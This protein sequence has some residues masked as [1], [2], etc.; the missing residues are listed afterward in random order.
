[1]VWSN[2]RSECE[3]FA[4]AFVYINTYNPFAFNSQIAYL[5]FIVIFKGENDEFYKDLL[6][7]AEYKA[8]SVKK[9]KKLNTLFASH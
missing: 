7:T 3:Q 8:S 6:Y 5:R 2:L 9:Y 1:M 4:S